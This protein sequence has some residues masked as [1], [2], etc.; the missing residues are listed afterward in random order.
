MHFL[1]KVSFYF[2]LLKSL[3]SAEFTMTASGIENFPVVESYDN[4]KNTFVIYSNQFQF[5]TNT[6]MFGFGVAD[7]VVEINGGKETQNI[8]NKV[9]D[10]F[11][12]IGYLKSIPSEENTDIPGAA[13]ASW[14][15]LGGTGPFA[16]LKGIVMTGAYFQMGQNRHKN[17]NF[18]W[19]GKAVNIP[20][21]L[22]EKI[23]SYKGKEEN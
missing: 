23:N 21:N 18:L 5:S 7:G 17:G 9:N 6:S 19:K 3:F 8:F 1:L 15:W 16:E 11:G 12:N 4:K 22:I 14:V 2:L 20:E 10:S 13:I